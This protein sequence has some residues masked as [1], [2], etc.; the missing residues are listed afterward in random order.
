L[1][2]SASHRESRH[3][4]SEESPQQKFRFAT[5]YESDNEEDISIATP[6]DPR[7]RSVEDQ[8][9]E[10]ETRI[11]TA[12]IEHILDI[13]DREPENPQDPG[14]PHYLTIVTGAVVQ[15]V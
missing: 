15:G 4:S 1:P 5:D 14:F 12:G 11:V 6:L 2:A 9:Q 8:Q 3:S 10:L 7:E 13:T